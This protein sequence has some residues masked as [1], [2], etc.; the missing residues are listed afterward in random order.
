MTP[1]KEDIIK[2]NDDGK[3]SFVHDCV[4]IPAT[5]LKGALAHRTAYHYNRIKG[6]YADEIAKENVKTHVLPT[7]VF[8]FSLAISSDKTKENKVLKNQIR[9]NVIFNDIIENKEEC[10]DK[11]LNHVAIDRFTGGAIDG[12]LFTEKTT[13]GMGMSFGTTDIII[14]SKIVDACKTSYPEIL[15]AFESA[16]TDV[17]KGMLP[18]GGG[19]NRGNGCFTGVLKRDNEVIYPKKGE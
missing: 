4:L 1:V 18:L 17:C 19:V 14:D 9:G 3:L 8:T 12:A 5:S 10:H 6:V 2:R 13:Y 15:K 7:W 11:I 16:L